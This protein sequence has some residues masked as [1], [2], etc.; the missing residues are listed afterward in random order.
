MGLP[1]DPTRDEDNQL[2][3]IDT[4]ALLVRHVRFIL[5]M[6]LGAAAIGG[7]VSAVRPP[8]YTATT[9]VTIQSGEAPVDDT[10]MQT[11]IALATTER[12]IRRAEEQLPDGADLS[13][14]QVEQEAPGVLVFTHISDDEESAQDGGSA[15]ASTYL[16]SRGERLR[17]R[18]VDA[19]NSLQERLALALSEKRSIDRKLADGQ[20]EELETRAQLLLL[21]ISRIEDA[22]AGL[23]P[24]L[25]SLQI[26]E[27]V[28]SDVSAVNRTFATVRGLLI[29][30]ILGL[31]AAVALLLL[32]HT[33][34]K[35]MREVR[36]STS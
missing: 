32:R 17:Q 26:G 20:D 7:L 18:T 1:S 36:S 10:Q 33:A 11:E 35:V 21:R 8:A 27:V 5:V 6:T 25:V 28:S 15:M 19:R 31:I 9:T 30:A 2:E 22:L 23:D 29:G 24:H 16:E 13:E 3:L 4:V 12:A 34:Q 14:V